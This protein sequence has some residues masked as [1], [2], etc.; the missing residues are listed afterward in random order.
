MRFRDY[1]PF[2]WLYTNYWAS[3]FHRAV[4]PVL[5]RV[6]LGS[7]PL[8][9][10]VLDLC[11]GDGR[12][13]AALEHRGFHVTGLD[14]SAQMLSFARR[15]A[16]SARFLLADARDFRLPATFDAALSTFDSLNH[17]MKT[18]D[19]KKVFGNVWTCLKPGG[20]FVFDLNSEEAY[21]DM[22]AQTASTVDTHIVSVARGSYSPATRLAVCDIT[23]LRVEDGI[24]KR[25]DFRMRQRWHR[26]ETVI[27]SLR[28][29]GFE[30]CLQG[31]DRLGMKGEMAYGRDFYI[32]R[33]RT[34]LPDDAS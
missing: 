4:L 12:L 29:A 27:R 25:S 17:V 20:S 28:S 2:A 26:K 30:A 10:S 8:G 11:C 16:S 23:L 3:A 9:A 24:W 32:A 22:W 21:K 15:R 6:V 14:G 18:E 33:K 34:R 13:A 5:E 7:L 19:L 1:D 31:A